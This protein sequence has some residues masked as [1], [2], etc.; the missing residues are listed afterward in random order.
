MAGP[1]RPSTLCGL[2]PQITRT[3]GVLA[4]PL[5]G[6]YLLP[7]TTRPIFVHE[8]CALWAPEVYCQENDGTLCKVSQAYRRGRHMR[9]YSCGSLG[10]TVGCQVTSCRKVFHFL[11]LQ[12]GRCAFVQA[13]YAAWCSRHASIIGDDA[14]KGNL[15]V[16]RPALDDAGKEDDGNDNDEEREEGDEGEG[17]EEEE[18]G[19][20]GEEG[21]EGKADDKVE[22]QSDAMMDHKGERGAAGDL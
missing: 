19:E 15:S 10:A 18:G 8:I 2:C 7:S 20:E 11:C 14:D 16:D 6:P 13:S 9:C 3:G 4:S 22:E 5:M 17:G 1:R 21:E 12:R